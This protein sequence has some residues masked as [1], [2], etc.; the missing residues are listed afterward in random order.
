LFLKKGDRS[1]IHYDT[2]DQVVKNICDSI[3]KKDTK[4]LGR[5]DFSAKYILKVF[6]DRQGRRH[7]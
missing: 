5:D 6:A 7:A 2:K 3:E 1:V 4:Y